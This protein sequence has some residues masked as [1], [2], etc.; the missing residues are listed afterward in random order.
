M[1][2]I[3]LLMLLIGSLTGFFL[4]QPAASLEILRMT[5]T[6]VDV[7]T[8]RQIVI[9]FNQPVV[10][11]G[12]MERDTAEMPITITPALQ[13]QWRWLNTAS[14]ACQLGDEN[15]LKP[16]TRYEVQVAPGIMTESGQTLNAPFHN[17]FITER[18]TISYTSF[19]TWQA[20]GMPKIWVT[21]NQQ[22]TPD[23]VAQHLYLQKP[24]KERVAVR[25][26][27]P[28]IE[29]EEEPLSSQFSSVW[30]VSPKILLPFGLNPGFS[31]RSALNLAL[32]NAS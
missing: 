3:R 29:D 16:A 11:L 18:P 30:I 31:R 28:P 12:K 27:L 14:L 9:T 7:P 5:P 17:T 22:V 26:E 32:R 6:G 23:S 2:K 25:V 4:A 10:P 20:P 15:A 19:H 1:T 21:F 8:G 13:C 24:N